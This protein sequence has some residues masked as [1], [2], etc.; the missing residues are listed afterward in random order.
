MDGKAGGVSG[1]V[2]QFPGRSGINALVERHVVGV[3][4]GIDHIRVSGRNLNRG[5]LS[6]QQVSDW[7]P[8]QF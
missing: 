3:D 5:E 2:N 1:G 4:S 8:T 7:L 6:S